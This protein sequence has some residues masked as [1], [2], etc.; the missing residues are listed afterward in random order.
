M[1][2]REW[3]GRLAPVTRPDP[4]NPAETDEFLR[5][6]LAHHR[7]GEHAKA[8]ECYLALLAERPEHPRALFL[9]GDLACSAGRYSEAVQRIRT[10]IALQPD[11]V[12]GYRSLGHALRMQ[13]ELDGAIEIFRQALA[14]D[15]GSAEIHLHIG[16]VQRRQG[17]YD[18]ALA[19]CLA[20]VALAPGLALARNNLGNAYTDLGRPEEAITAYRGALELDPELAE[21]HLNLGTSLHQGGEVEPASKHYRAA[22]ALNPELADGH[23]NLGYA[24]EQLG[25]P[26]G[27]IECYRRTISIDPDRA[28]A[29]FN[30][31]LQLLLIGDFAQGWEE[32]EWRWQLPG[33]S[34]VNPHS[35][36]RH[37]DGSALAGESILLY[38]EQGF[39]DAI[40]FLRYAPLAAKGAGK[41]IVRCAPELQ[42]L[43][44][45]TSNISA[46]VNTAEP[47]PECDLCCSLLSL[48]RLLG[49][50]LQSIPAPIPY[51]RADPAKTWR[52]H[53][54]IAADG[55]GLKV[56]LVWAS[57]AVNKIAR[58]KSLKLEMLGSM[59]A[60]ENVVFYSLQKGAAASEAANPPRGMRIV[61]ASAELADFSDTAALIANLDLVI[62]VDTAVAHLAGAMGKPVWTMTHFPP[63]WRWMLGRDDSP[64]YPTMRL[65]RQQHPRH[66]A[67]VVAQVA[68]AL[69]RMAIRRRV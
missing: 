57:Q 37:W 43:F 17:R 10:A 48:P 50:M 36:S 27:A 21:A 32:Y 23:L 65:F 45:C 30:L 28:D 69:T 46:V 35:A 7:A 15:P 6:G 67:S 63:D 29:H 68:E 25:D 40:Q 39:G 38:A 5:A 3:L 61:D 18:E 26:R 16:D 51:L 64:W 34:D 20:A 59:G 44:E 49:T 60:I 31:A 9:L 33:L 8:E 58:S 2:F 24:H 47:I 19:S 22:L 66:W 52:L 13:G 55:A 42:R 53:E 41:V 14:L 1:K 62:S 54:R 11:H 12:P 4:K 56:G